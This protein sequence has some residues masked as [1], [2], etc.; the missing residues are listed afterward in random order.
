ML[1]AVVIL[2]LAVSQL[3]RADGCVKI[4]ATGDF[5]TLD[6]GRHLSSW[7]NAQAGP[8]TLGC[9]HRASAV[10]LLGDNFYNYGVESTSDSL[11]TTIYEQQFN[12]PNIKKIPHYVVAGNHDHYSRVGITAELQYASTRPGTPWTFPS[13]YYSK[14]IRHG[15]LTIYCVF[16][17]T[18][19]LI[20]GDSETASGRRL[21]SNEKGQ[22][23]HEHHGNVEKGRRRLRGSQSKSSKKRRRLEQS[24]VDLKQLQWIESQISSVEAQSADWLLVIGHY[25]VRSAALGH[26]DTQALVKDLEPLL[27]KYKVDAYLAGH[28]HVSQILKNNG[29]VYYGNGAGGQLHAGKDSTHPSLVEFVENTFGFFSHVFNSTCL[30][31]RIHYED[32]T[33]SKE[34]IVEYVQPKQQRIVT[35]SPSSSAPT[36]AP[37]ASSPSSSSLTSMSPS[38]SSPLSTSS[39]SS[40]TS[41]A[42][43][44]ATVSPSS[45]SEE[46]HYL[47]WTWA[48]LLESFHN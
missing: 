44:V 1:I 11:W 35:K 42:S 26:S 2:L 20:G 31:T 47:G 28:D 46:L 15:N 4:L 7:F 13:N 18:W 25:P 9:S 19:D 17:D 41:P 48:S 36:L 10:F 16:I 6:F 21:D 14:I 22:H 38:S 39:P 30:V 24:I 37:S 27:L 34:T 45:S 12:G 29:I 32:L 33:T 5:G 40:T 23:G 3:A 43:S 8:H